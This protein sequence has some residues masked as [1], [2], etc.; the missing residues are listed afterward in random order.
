MTE[1]EII[2]AHMLKNEAAL[3]AVLARLTTARIAIEAAIEVI[4]RRLVDNHLEILK[5]T[6]PPDEA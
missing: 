3:I 2:A 5:L 1:S 6:E 4:D